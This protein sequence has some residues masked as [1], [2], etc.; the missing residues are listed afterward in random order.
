MSE[1]LPNVGRR[2]AVG[3][4]VGFVVMAG[5]SPSLGAWARSGDVQS[6]EACRLYEAENPETKNQMVVVES[7][8]KE[9]L[10]AC[11]LSRYLEG[12]SP[13]PYSSDNDPDLDTTLGKEIDYS[14]ALVRLPEPSRLEKRLSS[15]K[16]VNELVL[17]GGG[18]G[19]FLGGM[20][21]F[22]WAARPRATIKLP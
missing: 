21:G 10:T 1:S 5:A 11:G 12:P 7:I 16:N 19:G 4:A 14:G 15:L 20:I 22:L 8:P 2:I 17:M 9:V 3:A 13:Y 6:L 18:M